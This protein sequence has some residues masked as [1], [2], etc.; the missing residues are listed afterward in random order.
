[1]SSESIRVKIFDTDFFL[2]CD[3]DPDTTRQVALYVN[4]KIAELQELTASRDNMKMA[5]LCALNLAGELFEAKAKY[6]AE[7]RKVQAYEEKI[8]RL[9]E[10]IGEIKKAG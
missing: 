2:R 5:V 9:N 1:M 3:A 4:S 10:T 7:V 8:K 6:E